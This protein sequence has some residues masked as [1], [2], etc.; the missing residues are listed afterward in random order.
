MYKEKRCIKCKKIIVD[1]DSWF[2][3]SPGCAEP[4]KSLGVVAI[5]AVIIFLIK[6]NIKLIFHIG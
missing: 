6:R 1:G 3:M 4:Y 5:F 2:G